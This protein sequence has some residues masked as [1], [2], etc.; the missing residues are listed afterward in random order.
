MQILPSANITENVTENVEV[1]MDVL[2][3]EALG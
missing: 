2:R 3:A 1:K